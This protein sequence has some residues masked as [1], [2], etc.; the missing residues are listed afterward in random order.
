MKAKILSFAQI[1]GE[2]LF[3]MWDHYKT[4]LLNYPQRDLNLYKE[5]QTFYNGV[6]MY[7]RKLID[8]QG[9]IMKRNLMGDYQ[10]LVETFTRMAF[11]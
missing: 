2:T 9:L 7:T 1:K 4:M 10:K 11:N 6:N 8:S 3:E 5:S